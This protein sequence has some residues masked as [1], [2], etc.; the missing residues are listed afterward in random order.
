MSMGVVGLTIHLLV[1][2]LRA[3][4]GAT[5]PTGMILTVASIVVI[6]IVAYVLKRAFR[7][8]VG[9]DS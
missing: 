4:T 7:M 5:S 8:L 1:W 9:S 6:N 3:G 2:P